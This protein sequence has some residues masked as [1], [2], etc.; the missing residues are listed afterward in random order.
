MRVGLLGIS[1]ALAILA[2]VMPQKASAQTICTQQF[3]PVCAVK[4][5]VQRTY[6]NACFARADG[7]RIIAN[8]PCARMP[9]PR[10]P[11][12]IHSRG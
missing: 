4:R 9:S 5:G 8:G 1:A 12:P 10:P 7:A 3:D 2:V 11:R 6:S